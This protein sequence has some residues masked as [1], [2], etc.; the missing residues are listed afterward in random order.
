MF[1]GWLVSSGRRGGG[2][3][4]NPFFGFFGRGYGVEA[5][6]LIF[7][8]N[9]SRFVVGGR[10]SLVSKIV[11]NVCPEDRMEVPRTGF[12]WR[13]CITAH[14][15]NTQ[16][17]N[18]VS[19]NFVRRFSHNKFCPHIRTMDCRRGEVESESSPLDEKTSKSFV[20]VKLQLVV[21][22]KLRQRKPW[23]MQQVSAAIN[24]WSSSPPVS[25]TPARTPIISTHQ[26]TI[27]SPHDS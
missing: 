12:F 11:V 27:N 6:F 26:P 25:R 16:K 18:P 7:C 8:E 13:Y 4:T 22:V 3:A 23:T 21:M 20:M 10:E 9:C 19:S 1:R 5:G 15:G 24:S 14:D 2:W 17:N